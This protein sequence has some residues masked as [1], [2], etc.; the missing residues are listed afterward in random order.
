MDWNNSKDETHTDSF[1]ENRSTQPLLDNEPLT[2]PQSGSSRTCLIVSATA[3]LVLN[4]CLLAFS[5]SIMFAPIKPEGLISYCKQ[6]QFP[7]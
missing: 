4:I 2:T 6:S 3:F 1:D 7:P 5:L